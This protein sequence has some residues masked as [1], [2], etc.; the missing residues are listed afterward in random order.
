MQIGEI[1]LEEPS[2]WHRF[3][4]GGLG[5]R[6]DRLTLAKRPG[7]AQLADDL[8]DAVGVSWQFPVM[9]ASMSKLPG[10]LTDE[11]DQSLG[12]GHCIGEKR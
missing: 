7:F 11:P 12:V 5:R 3:R 6:R 8:L 10:L 9:S 2:S 1:G 4:P